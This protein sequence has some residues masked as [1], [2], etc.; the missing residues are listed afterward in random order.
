MLKTF[1]PSQETYMNF[2]RPMTT[3]AIQRVLK[4]YGVAQGTQV[5]YSG[6]SGVSKLP[7]SDS[8]DQSRTDLYTDGVFR[9]K[10][11][12]VVEHESSSFNTGYGNSRRSSTER[13]I[14]WDEELK[15]MVTP[16]YEGRLCTVEMNCHFPSRIKAQ[17]FINV[18]NRKQANQMADFNFD[19]TVHTVFNE[20]ILSLIESVHDTIAKHDPTV[21]E[22]S[23]WFSE[24]SQVPLTTIMNK[25]GNNQQL[26]VPFLMRNQGIQFGEP[27]IRQAQRADIFG[28]YEAVVPFYF[29]YQEFI[30]YEV[31]YPLEVYQEEIDSVY[32]PR[33][34]PGTKPFSLR[35]NVELGLTNLIWDSS[36][37]SVVPYYTVLPDHDLWRIPKRPYLVPIVQARLFVQN[38]PSQVLCN[39]FEIPTFTFNDELVSYVLR[40]RESIFDGYSCPF[41][42]NIYSNDLMIEPEQLSMDESGNIT[43]HR[44]PS[45]KNTH[46]LTVCINHGL[47]DWDD[48]TWKDLDENPENKPVLNLLFPEYEWDEVIRYPL[49]PQLPKIK[50]DIDSGDG[51]NLV[52][53]DRYMMD[54]GLKVYTP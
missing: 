43:L 4:F 28:K 19:A 36:R 3:E 17:Q 8:V 30:G 10:V 1:V 49:V 53:W 45:I 51:L 15:L 47:R 12:C 2:V 40:N 22:L 37:S 29:H 46:H 6:E 23:K 31:E 20:G 48:K 52:Q 13:P 21:D 24:R 34:D 5:F 33:R 16:A 32:I 50:K 11:F 35:N 44:T 54:L 27:K 26:A 7:G 18:I 41:I 25:A 39:I 38:E 14:W 9:E 42:V